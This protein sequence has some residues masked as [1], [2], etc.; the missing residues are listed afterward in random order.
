MSNDRIRA[1]CAALLMPLLLASFAVSSLRAADAP[2]GE[3]S[4]AP[5]KSKPLQVIPPGDMQGRRQWLS[6]LLRTS[7]EF[8]DRQVAE[9]K[10]NMAAMSPDEVQ[11]AKYT[12]ATIKQLKD[13]V[14]RMSSD[15]VRKLL[16][17]WQN[18]SI[19][20]DRKAKSEA[21]RRQQRVDDAIQRQQDI[22][23]VRD[24]RREFTTRSIKES[25]RRIAAKRDTVRRESARAHNDY[26]RTRYNDPFRSPYWRPY[27]RYSRYL[28]Y[29]GPRR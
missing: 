11:G 16:R 25:E 9:F 26:L 13:N 3:S 29:Y 5:A 22:E 28:P 17:S 21:A 15:E 12:D 18:D 7:G 27:D 4:A 2:A 1:M 24:E 6:N 10:A 19:S 8:T 14:A 20:F 23:R